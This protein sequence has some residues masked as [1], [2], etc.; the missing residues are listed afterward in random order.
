M[1][2]HCFGVQLLQNPA[3]CSSTTQSALCINHCSE[4]KLSIGKIFTSLGMDYTANGS[5]DGKERSEKGKYIFPTSRKSMY[6]FARKLVPGNVYCT[7]VYCVTCD[8]ICFLVGTL[9]EVN[10]THFM[11]LDMARGRCFIF[12]DWHFR[13]LQIME[14]F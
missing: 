8:H 13:G 4:V 12:L 11:K 14:V 7:Y 1:C 2:K 6:S 5:K 10:C 9:F 3:L